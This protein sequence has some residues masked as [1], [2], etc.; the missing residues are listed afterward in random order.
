[1]TAAQRRRAAKE[2]IF[3]GGEKDSLKRSNNKV[4]TVIGETSKGKS[5]T[6]MGMRGSV[7]A[8]RAPML[9]KPSKRTPRPLSLENSLGPSCKSPNTYT[10]PHPRYWGKR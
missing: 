7:T 4:K 1:M 2:G 5:H 10:V 9:S 8:M 6:D 3:M